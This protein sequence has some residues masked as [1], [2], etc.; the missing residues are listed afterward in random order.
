MKKFIALFA[1]ITFVSTSCSDNPLDFTV[2]HTFDYSFD[3]NLQ[4]EINEFNE[5]FTFDATENDDVASN[6]D[7]INDYKIKKLE[8]QLSDYASELDNV[9]GSFT[10]SFKDKDGNPIGDLV[11][12]NISNLEALAGSG[13]KLDIPL[14]DATQT[15]VKNELLATNKITVVM[16][17][18]VT[19]TPVAFTAHVYLT[20]GID[21]KF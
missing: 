10:V 5:E 6:L 21:I 13:E 17:G 15:A 19:D 4:G 8:L 2:D 20:V 3:V 7:H 18:S 16:D 14:N 1:I 12:A 11:T 9:D